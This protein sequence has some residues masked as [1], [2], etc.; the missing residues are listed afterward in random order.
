MA[1]Y[2]PRNPTTSKVRV[3]FLKLAVVPKQTGR[4]IRP[5]GNAFFQERHHGSHRCLVGAAPCWVHHHCLLSNSHVSLC[6][7]RH[8]SCIFS[9]SSAHSFSSASSIIN[10]SNQHCSA[11]AAR[12]SN[13]FSLLS[14]HRQCWLSAILL[15]ARH[16]TSLTADT[17]YPDSSPKTMSTHAP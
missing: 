9:S 14:Y 11:T 5:T 17:D 16:I 1:W 15:S 2:V 7:H 4:S 12:L 13:I 10:I 3:S 6:H 8:I